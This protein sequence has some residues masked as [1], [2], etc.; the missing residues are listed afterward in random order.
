MSGF[1]LKQALLLSSQS[2]ASLLIEIPGNAVDYK[3]VAFCPDTEG[4][5]NILKIY[6]IEGGKVAPEPHRGM[7]FS[8]LDN[9]V[10]FVSDYGFKVD[11][12]WTASEVE[13]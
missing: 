8:S 1:S 6:A 11:D 9:L 10:E 13:E 12:R 4:K 2:R 3:L 5:E 7:A